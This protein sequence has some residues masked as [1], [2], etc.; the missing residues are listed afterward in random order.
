MR[1]LIVNGFTKNQ[2]GYKK[3]SDF[4]YIIMKICAEQKELMDTET[5]C[6]IRDRDNIDDFLYEIDSGYLLK[7]SAINFDLLDIVFISGDVNTRP[8]A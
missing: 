3:F 1:I 4:Q 5:E 6:F 7:E 8:W 2:D